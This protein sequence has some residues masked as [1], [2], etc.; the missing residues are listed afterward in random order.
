MADKSSTGD[1]EFMLVMGA[2]FVALAAS[3]GIVFILGK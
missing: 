2:L 3:V 1:D